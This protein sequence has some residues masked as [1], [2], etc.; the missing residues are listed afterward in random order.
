MK[1]AVVV[2]AMIVSLAGVASAEDSCQP[3][4]RHTKQQRTQRRLE[5][6]ARRIQK[7]IRTY[8]RN[9]DG[10]VDPSELPPRL[11]AKMQTLDRNH[12][13]WVDAADLDAPLATGPRR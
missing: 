5:H 4:P 7:V 11:A 13:G 8:D 3:A 1:L 12:D 10:V 2:I 9:H 6:R